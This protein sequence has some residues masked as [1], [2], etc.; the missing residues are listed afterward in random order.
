MPT[1]DTH[2]SQLYQ[3][4]LLVLFFFVAVIIYTSS[5]LQTFTYHW[6]VVGAVVLMAV[7]KFLCSLTVMWYDWVLLI[8]M[9]IGSFLLTY[10]DVDVAWW[11]AIILL[12]AFIVDFVYVAYCAWSKKESKVENTNKNFAYLTLLADFVGVVAI[13]FVFF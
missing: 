2:S 3:T 8:A 13:A 10:S 12:L 4:I 9:G 5:Y 1:S 11:G 6:L 7:S